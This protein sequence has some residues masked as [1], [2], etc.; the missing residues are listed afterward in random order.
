[1][2]ILLCQQIISLSL[3][4][5]HLLHSVGT[6]CCLHDGPVNTHNDSKITLFNGESLA[7][8]VEILETRKEFKS[9]YS[10]VDLPFECNTTRIS[11]EMLPK[12]YWL[13]Q[14]STEVDATEAI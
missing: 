4:N 7:T 9:K 1:M 2:Q 12:I 8:C 11:Y 10:D 14:G 6:V 3:L 13:V 5:T